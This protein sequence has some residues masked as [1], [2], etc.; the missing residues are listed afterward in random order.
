VAGNAFEEKL[1]A[2]QAQPAERPQATGRPIHLRVIAAHG[3]SVGHGRS[4]EISGDG[5]SLR[6]NTMLPAGLRMQLRFLSPS[7]EH[8]DYLDVGAEVLFSVMTSGSPP[9]R[10]GVKFVGADAEF[11]RRLRVVLQR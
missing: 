4:N 11:R 8:F 2:R 5:A 3:T 10:V 6:L 9:C 1:Q 7:S